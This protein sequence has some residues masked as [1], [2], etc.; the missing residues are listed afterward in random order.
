MG[1]PPLP[2]N[3]R[4]ILERSA[5]Q[6]SGCWHWTGC[7]R[8]DGYGKTTANGKQALA[9]RLA[10]C[11]WAGMK[12]NDERLV[13]HKCNNKRCV[14]PVHLYAGTQYDNVQDYRRIG[15]NPTYDRRGKRNPRALFD[16]AE[17]NAIKRLLADGV[18]VKVIQEMFSCSNRPIYAIKRGTHWSQT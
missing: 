5:K 7:L 13:L 2:R 16:A 4:Y 14:N 3:R 15:I 6:T 8:P 17:C 10:Y 11:I 1:R 12:M 9:H 18:S